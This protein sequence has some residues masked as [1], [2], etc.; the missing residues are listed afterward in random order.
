MNVYSQKP[1]P[2][3]KFITRNHGTFVVKDVIEYSSTRTLASPTAEATLIFKGLEWKGEGISS[4]RGRHIDETLDLYDM[5][6]VR[7][8]DGQGKYW[9]DI[10]GLVH[11]IRVV[12]SEQDGR[13]L[14]FV[15]IKLVGLGQ[16]LVTYHVFWHNHVAGRSNLGGIGYRVRSGGDVPKGRP[17]Q[18]LRSLY[19]AFF[20]DDYVFQL[21]DGRKIVDVFLPAFEK[22]KESL[23]ILGLSAMGM[24]GSLWNSLVR[25]ADLPFNE[26]Y[27]E[28]DY[29][30]EVDPLGVNK[31]DFARIIL[32]PTPFDQKS[33]GNLVQGGT[34]HSFTYETSERM[35]GGENIAR[36]VEGL[37][38]FFWCSGKGILSNFDQ[39]SALYN[40]SNG[41][42]PII[43]EDSV[44]KF[45]L[46]RHEETTEYIQDFK[47]IHESTG[48]LEPS[49]K[50]QMQTSQSRREQLLIRRSMQLALWFGYPDFRKGSITTRGRIGTSK[51]HGARIG[52]VLTRKSDGMEFYI[53]GVEQSW[54]FPGPHTT[55][56]ALS[57]GHIPRDYAKW[58]LG[59]VKKMGDRVAKL[60]VDQLGVLD[61]PGFSF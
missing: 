27:V 23:S 43:D 6:R 5:C 7:L 36:S 52:S 60:V 48:D 35:G 57:R 11:E 38:N 37:G 39:L 4:V 8:C 50:T 53:T 20:N 14:Q 15:Q 46:R 56:F 55:T 16:V 1:Q 32:R 54:S 26:L 28:P 25:F 47:G 41:V 17:D 51:E 30:S 58:R 18:V 59:Q 29:P 40:Q 34:G 22:I 24:E 9:T 44:R 61:A 42:L 21:A 10:L 45:S 49:E 33:W 31:Q 19:D 2:E 13:P 12:E 3:I